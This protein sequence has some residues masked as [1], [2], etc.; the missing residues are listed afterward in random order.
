MKYS[1]FKY[2][3]QNL[4]L[5][6]Y[7]FYINEP[8]RFEN[9]WNKLI[10]CSQALHLINPT[11]STSEGR[12]KSWD[13]PYKDRSSYTFLDEEDFKIHFVLGHYL[14]FR[15]F[16]ECLKSDRASV[17]K[18]WNEQIQEHI[19]TCIL[20]Q[21]AND[22]EFPYVDELSFDEFE[23]DY[24]QQTGGLFDFLQNYVKFFR[25][26]KLT[27]CWRTMMYKYYKSGLIRAEQVVD[28]P[29]V[30]PYDCES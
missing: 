5:F 12:L 22:W 3:Y 13:F 6:D 26:I 4:F 29:Y 10:Y 27:V 1:M 17:I 28:I 15:E 16:H 30:L 25:R 19:R 11:L 23:F 7:S 20:P 18:L 2:L 8:K 9:I 14:N 24:I 21:S